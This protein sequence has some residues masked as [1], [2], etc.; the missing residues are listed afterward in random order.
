LKEFNVQM[1]L[2]EASVTSKKKGYQGSTVSHS[3]HSMN[4]PTKLILQTLQWWWL[5]GW[6]PA[7]T[8]VVWN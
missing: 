1:L 2:G 5:E 6:A 8:D 7:G 3:H 4:K